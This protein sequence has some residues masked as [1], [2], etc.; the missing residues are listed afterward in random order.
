VC[1]QNTATAGSRLVS[2]SKTI[3]NKKN[4][5]VFVLDSFQNIVAENAHL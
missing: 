3:L 5:H 1:S 2:A 4:G